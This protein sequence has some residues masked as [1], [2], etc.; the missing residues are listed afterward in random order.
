MSCTDSTGLD[1]FA[2]LLR[3]AHAGQVQDFISLHIYFDD[4][5][6]LRFAHTPA[7]L[8]RL[9]DVGR[10]VLAEEFGMSTGLVAE[11]EQA[12]YFRTLLFSTWAAG[13]AGHLG[14]CWSDFAAADLPPYTHHPFELFFGI[15]R[16][17]WSERPAA[18]EMHRFARLLAQVD[19]TRW[20]PAASQAAIL[21]PTTFYVNYPF[22]SVDR[23]RLLKTLLEAYTLARMAGF[24]AVFVREPALP[25]EGVRLLLVPFADLL[26][27]TW[28]Q[29]Q[30]WVEMGG[31]L[32]AG[33]GNS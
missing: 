16:A 9:C 24:D 11:E 27:P 30:A 3:R 31:V 1:D 21:V 25:P 26:A 17:D 32:W 23:P 19:A 14:W 7:G 6:T 29:L 15:T 2:H 33:F 8:V 12:A 20:A 10:P 4:S 22:R 5:D 28:Y 18:R 13:T